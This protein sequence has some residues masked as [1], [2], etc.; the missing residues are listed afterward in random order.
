[1]S[2]GMIVS[3]LYKLLAWEP[4]ITQVTYSYSSRLPAFNRKLRF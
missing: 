1:M 4:S 2:K 3:H